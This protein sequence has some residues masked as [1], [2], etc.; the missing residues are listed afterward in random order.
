MILGHP[1]DE[2]RKSVVELV[3]AGGALLAFFI[4]FDPALPQAVA[5]VAIAAIGVLA[6]YNAPHSYDDISK[7]L[8]SLVAAA[9][10]L[11]GFFNHYDAGEAERIVAIAAALVKVGAVFYVPNVS[12]S[13]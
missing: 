4:A 2:L 7:A 13:P 3:L 9:V 10:A 6:V 12:A 1:I 8:M 5:A 11:Y